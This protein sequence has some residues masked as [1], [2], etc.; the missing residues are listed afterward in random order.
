MI[1]FHSVDM[2]SYIK[3][4]NSDTLSKNVQCIYS[5]TSLGLVLQLVKPYLTV[6]NKSLDF[7]QDF[8][9]FLHRNK[10]DSKA[11]DK[12]ANFASNIQYPVELVINS[13]HNILNI[14]IQR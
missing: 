2:K 5:V 14:V 11:R 1:S 12:F 13:H 3:R 9:I 8:T 10:L 6:F 7:R 4:R